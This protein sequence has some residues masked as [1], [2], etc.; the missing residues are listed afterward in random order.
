M[1]SQSKVG[2]KRIAEKRIERLFELA[3]EESARKPAFARRYVKLARELARKAQ[4]QIPRQLK[5]S[6]CKKCNTPFTAK[7]RIRT[8]RGFVVYACLNCGARRRFKINR[9]A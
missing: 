6:F 3:G 2:V 7:S 4:V 1:K 9:K 5:R 8:K